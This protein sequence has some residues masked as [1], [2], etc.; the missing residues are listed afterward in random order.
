MSFTA[1]KRYKTFAEF[2]PFY[3]SQHREKGTRALHVLGTGLVLGNALAAA[4]L[5]RPRLLLLC[6]VLGYG[7]AW[8][9]HALLERNKPAT[10]T[11]P[12]YSLL[13]DFKMFFE[14]ITGRLTM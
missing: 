9:S 8:A 10:F 3:L 4:L 11:Y 6:P 1:P 12:F 14:I 13:A 5:L 2:Y 7:P